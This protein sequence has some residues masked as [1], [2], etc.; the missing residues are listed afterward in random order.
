MSVGDIEVM[1]SLGSY[2]TLF[3]TNFDVRTSVG[4]SNTLTQDFCFRKV[5]YARYGAPWARREDLG[6]LSPGR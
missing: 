3:S 6:Q 4:N 2:W 5:A 1:S